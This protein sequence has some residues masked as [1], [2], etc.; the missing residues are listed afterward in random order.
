[1]RGLPRAARGLTV[2]VGPVSYHVAMGR[3]FDGALSPNPHYYEIRGRAAEIARALGSPVGGAEHLFL[4]MLHDGGWPVNVIASLVDLGQAEAAVLR[5]LN[6]PGYLPPPRPRILV[7]AGYVRAWG[8]EI[9]FEMG[10]SYLGVEHAFLAMIRMRET[11]PARALAGLA[12]L[13]A[14]EAAVLAAKNAPAG[15][16]P[17]DAVFLPEGQEMD[18]PLRRAVADALPDSTTFSFSGDEGDRTWV[19]VIGPGDSSD[20]AV[21]RE[22]LNTAL[23]SLGRQMSAS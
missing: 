6:S 4:G 16:P 9:A 19:R 13:D 22:V 10:D 2:D 23:A 15:G 1:M 8:A 21:T 5:I 3:A 17:E 7:P 14:L 12:D 11:V 20:P 18:G